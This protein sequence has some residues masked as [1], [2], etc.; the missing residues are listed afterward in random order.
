MEGS[1]VCSRKS[2]EV[3]VAGRECWRGEY[4]GKRLDPCQGL[5]HVGPHRPSEDFVL[6]YASTG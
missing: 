2:R 1:L 3:R 4:E 6:T 5:R